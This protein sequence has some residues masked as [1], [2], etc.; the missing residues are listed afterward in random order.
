MYCTSCGKEIANDSKYCIHCGTVNPVFQTGAR[1]YD[2]NDKSSF[3]FAVLGFFFPIVGLILYLVFNDRTPLRAKSVGKGALAGVITQ[4]VTAIITSIII[5]MLCFAVIPIAIFGEEISDN[6][7][8][9]AYVDIYDEY[10]DY[11]YD[12]DYDEDSDEIIDMSDK[13]EVKLGA[14]KSGKYED[15]SSYSYLE[16]NV[17]NV[18]DETISCF[19]DVEAWKGETRLYKDSAYI[20]CL[21][22]G[23][24]DRQ[25]IFLHLENYEIEDLKD[26]SFKVT[27]V[28][29]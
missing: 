7:H 8:S 29:Y 24:T 12:F 18:S 28:F 15:G 22:A 13:V 5:I 2:P 19:V 6:I 21:E 26:A 17:K 11:D 9:N 27:D 20:E 23:K 16:V 1:Q 14:F 3:G 25:K 10:D 4:V